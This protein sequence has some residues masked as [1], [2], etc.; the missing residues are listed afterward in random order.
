L[1][2]DLRLSKLLLLILLL[3]LLHIRSLHHLLIE[4]GSRLLQTGCLVLLLLPKLHLLLVA[5]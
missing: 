1:H 3:L 4:A 2:N 5:W